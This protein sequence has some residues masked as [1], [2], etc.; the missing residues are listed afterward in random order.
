VDKSISFEHY[1]NGLSNG[2]YVQYEFIDNNYKKTYE[3]LRYIGW[4]YEDYN[5]KWK[6]DSLTLVKMSYKNW[7]EDYRL[8]RDIKIKANKYNIKDNYYFYESSKN[9]II[10]YKLDSIDHLK[11]NLR[12]MY[13]PNRLNKIEN[14]FTAIRLDGYYNRRVETSKKNV[15]KWYPKPDTLYP[16]Y[17]NENDTTYLIDSTFSYDIKIRFYSDGTFR[18]INVKLSDDFTDWSSDEVFYGDYIFEGNSIK[19]ENLKPGF[20]IKKA[21]FYGVNH[22]IIECGYPNTVKHRYVFDFVAD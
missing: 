5:Y 21:S 15:A 11:S 1:K 8:R 18:Q 3:C 2:R 13:F 14:P 7:T 22:N 17:Y 10:R 19:S 9:K 12:G 16:K 6:S 4:T 20:E